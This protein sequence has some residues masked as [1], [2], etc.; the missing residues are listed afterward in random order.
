MKVLPRSVFPRR[1]RTTTARDEFSTAGSMSP[2]AL[3]GGEEEAAVHDEHG[4]LVAG[5]LARSGPELGHPPGNQD[6]LAHVGPLRLAGDVQHDGERHA[7]EHGEVQGAGRGWPR[8]VSAIAAAGTRP[9][10]QAVRAGSMRR[11][12]NPAT[13][14][15]AARAGMGTIS[16]S[17]CGQEHDDGHGTPPKTLVQRDRAPAPMMRTVPEMEPPAGS[18]PTKTGG[19]VGGSLAEEVPRD[20]RVTGRP[21]WCRPG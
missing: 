7:E 4:Q 2:D 21:G 15:S 19:H 10:L 6:D 16:A 9:V 11:P 8:K 13:M 18:P 17:G 12:W 14:R 1:A 3:R 20:V 5:R